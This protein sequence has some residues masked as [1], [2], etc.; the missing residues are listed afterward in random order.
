MSASK[1]QGEG[2][3]T[4]EQW[5]TE[6]ERFAWPESETAAVWVESRADFEDFAEVPEGFESVVTY[7]G[8]GDIPTDGMRVAERFI[9]TFTPEQ[10]EAYAKAMGEPFARIS[11]GVRYCVGDNANIEGAPYDTLEEAREAFAAECST[12]DS[13]PRRVWLVKVEEVSEYG[14]VIEVRD[15]ETIDYAEIEPSA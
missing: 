10:A 7:Y 6:G 1:W 14:E 5:D 3:Y 11:Y 13:R 4:F 9:A 2:W 12:R 15:L 8:N